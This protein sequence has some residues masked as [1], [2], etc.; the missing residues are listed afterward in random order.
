MSRGGPVTPLT[1]GTPGS[2]ING[3][4]PLSLSKSL[5]FDENLYNQ[6]VHSPKTPSKEA[7]LYLRKNKNILDKASVNGGYVP[8]NKICDS[9]IPLLLDRLLYTVHIY[10]SIYVASSQGLLF[11]RSNRT[12]WYLDLDL[13][14]TNWFYSIFKNIHFILINFHRR[15]DDS[16]NCVPLYYKQRGVECILL[17]LLLLA[18]WEC[19]CSGRS[20]FYVKVRSE[21]DLDH[22]FI[23]R[24]PRLVVLI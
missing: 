1:P 21:N 8:V 12:E 5:S 2:W 23:E 9:I 14:H 4:S 11:A 10:S 19:M 7:F 22:F 20:L 6:L 24:S 3:M 13:I 15:G 16:N 17:L 18:I